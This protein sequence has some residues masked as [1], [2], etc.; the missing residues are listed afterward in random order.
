MRE[1]LDVVGEFAA[2]P[3]DRDRPLWEV[4]LV[5]GLADGRAGYVVKTHHSTT[6]GLGAVQLMSKLHSR[7][8]EHDPSRPEPPVPVPGA[9]TRTELLTE[10]IAE[11]VQAA[12]LAAAAPGRR[13]RRLLRPMEAASSG[14]WTPR[15]RRP[16]TLAPPPAARR[17]WR[18]RRRAGTSRCSRCRWPT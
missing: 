6:D 10:Q 15:G 9:V 17:C 12:P 1:L 7:T 14:A 2:A 3:L 18:A 8:A 13:A 11:A 4:L 16:R 5:E